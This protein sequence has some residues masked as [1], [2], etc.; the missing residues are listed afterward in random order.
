MV[1]LEDISIEELKTALDAVEK[2]KPTQR[3]TA[4]IAYKRGITQTEIASWY[5][6]QRKTIYNWL[7]RIENRSEPLVEAVTD[8]EPPGRPRRLSDQQLDELYEILQN[9]PTDAGYDTSTWTATLV[10]DL[11]EDRWNVEYSRWS[12]LRLLKE[13]D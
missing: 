3:L 4:A 11:I 12:C 1:E 2:K 5:G 13:V 9:P 10:E 6:V 8:D 7:S